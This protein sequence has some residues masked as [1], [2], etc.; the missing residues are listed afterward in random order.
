MM[1]DGRVVQTGPPEQVYAH[2]ASR[3]VAEFLGDADV[4]PGTAGGGFVDCELGR[5]PAPDDSAGAVEVV[6]RPESLVMAAPEAADGK[7]DARWVHGTV[8]SR[9][10]FG[11]DQLVTVA[12]A[13]GRT[14]DSRTD[15]RTAWR[16]GDDVR[17]SVAGQVSI[18][19]AGTDPS[20]AR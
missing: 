4:L 8:V 5:F 20:C 19:A 10:Y 18:L 1:R 16:A 6:V 2:P 3:W 9:E 14:V 11:H 12:L 13:S 7:P 17:V 15:G